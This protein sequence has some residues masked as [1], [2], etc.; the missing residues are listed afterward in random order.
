MKAA[1]IWGAVLVVVLAGAYAFGVW[2]KQQGATGVSPR[3]GYVG[4]QPTEIDLGE[5]LWDTV[6]PVELQ[7]INHGAS[8]ITIQSVRTSCDCAVVEAE[9]LEARVVAPGECLAVPVKLNTLKNPGLKKRTVQLTT[10]KGARYSAVI[11]VN[12]RGTWELAPDALD[13]G[14]VVLDNGEPGGMRSVFFNSETER[15]LE[16][17]APSAPWIE[18]RTTENRPGNTEILIS[19]HTGCLPIGQNS[20]SLLVRT[21]SSVKPTGAVYVKARGVHELSPSPPAVL[22]L[23]DKHERV[24]FSDRTGKRVHIVCVEV[25]SGSI[26]ALTLEDGAIEIWN[27]TGKALSERIAVRVVDDRGRCRVIHVSAF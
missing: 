8:P 20:A 14:D 15:L 27:S 4:F 23:G 25:S 1:V 2:Q 9:G 26:F 18:W 12:V 24:E 3:L 6:V 22:L 13:F 7:F 21:S 17:S 11:I 5:H 16:V 10:T 19:V